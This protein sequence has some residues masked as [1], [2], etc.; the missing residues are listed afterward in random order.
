MGTFLDHLEDAAKERRALE[1]R[2]RQDRAETRADYLKRTA[3]RGPARVLRSSSMAP[4]V[5]PEEPQDP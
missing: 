1:Q 5:K 3:T 2:E 4:A